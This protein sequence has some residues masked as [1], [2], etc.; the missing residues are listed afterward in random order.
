MDDQLA[1]T[2]AARLVFDLSSRRW[3]RGIGAW[4]NGGPWPTR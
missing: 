1:G 2:I 3:S 4:N